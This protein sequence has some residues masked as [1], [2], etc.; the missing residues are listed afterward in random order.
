MTP[1]GTFELCCVYTAQLMTHT[2]IYTLP[3]TLHLCYKPLG[4]M[5]RVTKSQRFIYQVYGKPYVL[6]IY[7]HT[8]YSHESPFQLDFFVDLTN[9]NT[10]KSREKNGFALRF[11]HKNNKTTLQAQDSIPKK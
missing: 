11:L 3:F 1:R 2:A 8:N 7:P 10:K 9:H 6:T 4:I 5:Q